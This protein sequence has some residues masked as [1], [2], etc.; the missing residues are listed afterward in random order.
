[1]HHIRKSAN[2]TRERSPRN[3][4]RLHFVQGEKPTASRL[5]DVVNGI[6]ERVPLNDPSRFGILQGLAGLGIAMCLGAQ[7]IVC[8]VTPLKVQYSTPKG[9]R[10]TSLR[11]RTEAFPSYCVESVGIRTLSRALTVVP[12][13]VQC[14][15]FVSPPQNATRETIGANWFWCEGKE[16]RNICS[17][18][19]A[20]TFSTQT[21]PFQGLP[22]GPD[23]P[24]TI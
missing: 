22:V 18:N 21:L 19:F 13:C 20:V 4:S 6:C 17:I 23:A 9:R 16:S 24:N 8:D 1:M 7:V 10:F 15:Y 2:S 5:V 11:H 14:T 3:N 12:C